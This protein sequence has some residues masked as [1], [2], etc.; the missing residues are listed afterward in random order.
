MGLVEG[1]IA[2]FKA[3]LGGGRV[4]GHGRLGR[5]LSRGRRAPSTWSTRSL[6]LWGLLRVYQLNAEGTP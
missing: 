3:E 5:P 2:R 4:V 1:I 6:S